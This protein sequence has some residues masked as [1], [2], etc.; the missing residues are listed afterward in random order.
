[1]KPGIVLLRKG[2][3]KMIR[4][5]LVTRVENKITKEVREIYG[6][7]DAVK[8]E[9]DGYKIIDNFKRRY[10]MSDSTFAKYGEKVEE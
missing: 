7:Y 1:M 9:N 6:R 2:K 8:I 10:K 5:I 3:R 4:T